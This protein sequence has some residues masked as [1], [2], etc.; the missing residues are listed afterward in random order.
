MK[1]SKRPVL[2][3]SL[4]Q[5]RLL[6]AVVVTL[7]S[8]L[9][10]SVLSVLA[11]GFR[12]SAA[13][14]LYPALLVT[15]MRDSHWPDAGL[16]TG[17]LVTGFRAWIDVLNGSTLSAALY[18]EYPG[19]IFYVVYDLLLCILVKDRRSVSPS[20]LWMV[21]WLCD[22]LSNTLNL[23]LSS[24]LSLE[25]ITT[26]LFTI[27]ALALVRSLPAAAFLWGTQ[28]YRQ[29]LLREE[30]E[31][32]Y[33]KLFLMTAELKTE[34]YF[35]KKDAEDIETVMSHAY[36]LYEQLDRNQAPEE[37]TSLALAIAR[38][39]HEVK[40]DNL[41]IIRG[42]EEEVAGSYDHESMSLTDMFHILEVS[43]R[44]FLGAQ[45]ANIRLECHCREDLPIREHYRLLSLL[46]NLVTNAV[47][48]IQADRRRGEVLVDC[49]RDGD[50]LVFQVLDD[51]PGIPPRGMKLLFKVGYSTKFNP[52]TG[53]INR[54]VGLSAVQ[55]IADELGGTIQVDSAP[56]Q[57]AKF[58]VR[59][60]LDRVI[61]GDES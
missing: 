34:L 16:V 19:G 45:R 22:F 52:E 44:Q 35:L 11:E 58:Q 47:E 26:E 28:S 5:R 23:A 40:K 46:K 17:L 4:W 33:H 60:P 57:G 37:L 31:Q 41:R 7:T 48:A 51:G 36:Q 59:L 30:H 10:L 12:V 1:V 54:G 43:T 3:L 38:E 15:L 49:W 56:G 9:Y 6:I 21:F 20:R 8:Q 27:A 25:A 14:T 53:D 55:Y 39:V 2:R 32:R 13:A 50:S 24:H 18:L 42:I 29:L 61:G